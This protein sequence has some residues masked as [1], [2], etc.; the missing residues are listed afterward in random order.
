MERKDLWG[1]GRKDGG[2]DQAKRGVKVGTN[3]YS[4]GWLGCGGMCG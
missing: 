1:M 3:N 4:L 2:R